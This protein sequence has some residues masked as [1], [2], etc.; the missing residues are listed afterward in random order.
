MQT[1]VTEDIKGWQPIQFFLDDD[2]IGVAEVSINHM[3]SKRSGLYILAARCT[4]LEYKDGD[5]CKH[6]TLI[7]ARVKE[8]GGKY[9][10]QLRDRDV[11][12]DAATASPE[13]FRELVLMNSVI[14]VMD[15]EG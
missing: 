11:D 4:C 15:G 12:L 7:S 2:P 14:E 8:T 3:M 9:A 13:A 1:T 5:G 10:L 6:I